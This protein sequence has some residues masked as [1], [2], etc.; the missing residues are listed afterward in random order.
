M[1]YDGGPTQTVDVHSFCTQPA[2]PAD[3]AGRSNLV[4]S[5]NA[6]LAYYLALLKMMSARLLIRMALKS[7]IS[8]QCQP[9]M[10][11]AWWKGKLA[12]VY[13]EHLMLSETYMKDLVRSKL[14]LFESLRRALPGH[15]Q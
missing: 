11:G 5:S 14:S 2:K 10:G 4:V 8:N 12:C 1:P 9:L 7:C 6:A 13:V 3:E 15:T